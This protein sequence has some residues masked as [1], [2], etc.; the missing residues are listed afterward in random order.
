[1][2]T[3]I[4]KGTTTTKRR[5]RGEVRTDGAVLVRVVPTKDGKYREY[6]GTQKDYD[7][8]AKMFKEYT[9]RYRGKGSLMYRIRRTL[10]RWLA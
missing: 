8:T 6:W 2:K 5:S 3:K 7:R 9:A 10:R 1:M 4:L